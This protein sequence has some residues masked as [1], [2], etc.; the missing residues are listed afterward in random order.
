MGTRCLLA[1]IALLIALIAPVFSYPTRAS[2]Q[3]HDHIGVSSILRMLKDQIL[4]R[5]RGTATG[6]SVTRFKG[7]EDNFNPLSFGAA[8]AWPPKT[9]IPSWGLGRVNP[10]TDSVILAGDNDLALDGATK[11]S[12][13]QD[14]RGSDYGHGFFFGKRV[15]GGKVNRQR[16][17]SGMHRDRRPSDYNWGMWFGKRGKSNNAYGWGGFFGKRG[18][19]DIIEYDDFVA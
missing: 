1:L 4:N 14:K 18:E 6:D 19:G 11:V 3:S 17:E 16:D 5:S 10:E 8:P 9:R 13:I 7:Q 15:P 2:E 12:D